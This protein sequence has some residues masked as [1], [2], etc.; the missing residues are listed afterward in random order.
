MAATRGREWFDDDSL[1][2]D[3]Y[4]FMFPQERSSKGVEEV[5]QVLALTQP[6]GPLNLCCGPGRHSVA[7]AQRG[8]SVTGVDRSEFLLGK[9]GER[10]AEAEVDV[11]WVRSDMRDFVRPEAFDLALSMFTSFGYFQD[12]QEDLLVLGNVLESLRPG[13]KFLIE[14]MGKECLARIFQPT[15]SEALADG[16]K[17]V[18][19]HEV[20][21][22]W[23]RIRNEWLLIR[24]ER[25][26]S[27][28][29]HHTIYSGQELRDRMEGAGFAQVDLY[30]SLEGDQYGLDA[31]RLVAVG[32]KAASR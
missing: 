25:V 26:K 22:D 6:A 5:A 17:L 4:P 7:L 8:L 12:K 24:G 1:W 11:E 30:G 27:F 15:T 31:Q 19:R 18:Q 14:V 13:G 16:S 3:L 23:T 21:D 32:R 20:F 10:A 2:R 29:F 9:A 28:K